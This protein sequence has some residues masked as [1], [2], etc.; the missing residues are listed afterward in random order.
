MIGAAGDG[1]DQY[2]R[3]RQFFDPKV[4]I[5]RPLRLRDMGHARWCRVRVSVYACHRFGSANDTDKGPADIPKWLK[6]G[7]RKRFLLMQES[8]CLA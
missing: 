7:S 6:L 4:H 3:E 8:N 1:E 2:Q 5:R